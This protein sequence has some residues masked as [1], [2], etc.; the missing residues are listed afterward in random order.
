LA[1]VSFYARAGFLVRPFPSARQQDRAEKS[2]VQQ[3]IKKESKFAGGSC[4]RLLEKQEIPR[5]SKRVA[6]KPIPHAEL[7]F[8]LVFPAVSN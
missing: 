7:R 8:V 4:T 5:L 2:S 1:S 3:K 6:G